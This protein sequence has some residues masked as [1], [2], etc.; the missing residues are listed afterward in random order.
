MRQGREPNPAAPDGSATV[1]H[2]S[3]YAL[4]G[5]LLFNCHNIDETLH[6]ARWRVMRGL[7]AP[8]ERKNHWTLS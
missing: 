7:M 1:M 4:F 6:G 2:C 5:V 8:L 3:R